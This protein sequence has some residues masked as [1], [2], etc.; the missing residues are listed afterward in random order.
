MWEDSPTFLIRRKNHYKAGHKINKQLTALG[1]VFQTFQN[2]WYLPS[3]CNPHCSFWWTQINEPIFHL[4]ICFFSFILS[5]VFCFGNNSRVSLRGFP[6]GNSLVHS[7]RQCSLDECRN[8]T[9]CDFF[10]LYGT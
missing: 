5:L 3:L 10:S 2:K 9:S 4:F 6:K 1:N 7:C 8:S